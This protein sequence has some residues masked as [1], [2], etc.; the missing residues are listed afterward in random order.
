MRRF[1]FNR[2]G[3]SMSTLPYVTAPGNVAKA[4][5]GI[6]SAAT[7]ERVSQDFVKTVLKI[8]SGSGNQ[9]ASYLRK[10][11]FANP[12][13]APSDLYKQF[14]NEATRGTAA[15]VALR[16]GYAGLFRRNEYVHELPDPKLKGLVIEETG[17]E[18]ESAAVRNIVSCFK[19]LKAYASSKAATIAE[20]QKPNV[21]KLPVPHDIATARQSTNGVGLNLSYT[22]NL[23]LPATSDVAVFNAIFQ[24]LKENLLRRDDE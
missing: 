18:S 6:I 21:T 19:H 13:G 15:A 10:I 5:N 23:N 11:G 16:Q 7:P 20:E 24:S 12:D 8:P 4:L 17:A 14:R 9:M 1:T 2:V 22:I 3:E